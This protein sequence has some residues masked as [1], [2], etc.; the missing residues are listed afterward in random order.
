MALDLCKKNG[1]RVIS[2]KMHC[3]LYYI[4][5]NRYKTNDRGV[6]AISISDIYNEILHNVKERQFGKYHMR[7]NGDNVD[8]FPSKILYYFKKIYSKL[9]LSPGQV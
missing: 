3:I 6:T 8:T 9:T 2:F 1:F 5:H 4:I 7:S